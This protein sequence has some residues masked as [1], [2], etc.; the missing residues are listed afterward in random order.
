LIKGTHK[1]LLSGVRGHYKNPG[2]IR[3]S[4]NWIGGSSLTDAFFIPPPHTDLP[5]LLTDLEK[6]WHNK[7]LNVPLL[8]K[9]GISHYQFETIHPFLDG[10]GRAGRLLIALHLIESKILTRPTLYLSAFFAKNRSSYY[11]SLNMV[12]KN[13]DF[14]QWMTFFLR[15]VIY[16]AND[17]IN[18][19][20][21]I[22]NL[23]QEYEQKILS[24]GVRAK[25][26]QRL[27]LYMFS[28]PIVSTKIVERNLGISNNNANRLI[29]SLVDLNI[30]IETT[31]YS[32]NRLYSLNDYLSLF[33]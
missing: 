17:A 13:N 19:F 7:N 2:E 27:L 14:K 29:K 6:F 30:L 8:I 20:K 21:D 31:G 16:T 10:N 22:I 5:E 23:R 1:R 25:N 9:I 18:V 12:R 3:G 11:D 15:G 32:R 24:L 33:N 4:Q 26:A 28:H